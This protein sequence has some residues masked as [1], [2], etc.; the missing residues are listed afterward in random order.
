[1]RVRWTRRALRALDGIAEYIAQD[2]PSA[3]RRIVR[4]IQDAVADLDAHPWMG[5]AGR[6]AGTRELV[7]AG[8]PFLIPYR[9]REETLEILSVIHA[10]RKWPDEF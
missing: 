10:A 9:V 4:R 8:T 7:V 2:S 6:V 1:M 5:R 3:A